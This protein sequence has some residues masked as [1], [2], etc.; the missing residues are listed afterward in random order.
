MK[1]EYQLIAD[2]LKEIKLRK[3]QLMMEAKRGNLAQRQSTVDLQR[4]RR[5]LD[6]LIA[7]QRQPSTNR[8]RANNVVVIDDDVEL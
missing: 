2:R 4:I 7:A 8:V 3:Q 5:E 6:Q 1:L